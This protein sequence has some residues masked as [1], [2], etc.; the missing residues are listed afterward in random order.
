MW[1]N[2]GHNE[3]LEAKQMVEVKV[4]PCP[5]CGSNE[6]LSITTRETFDKLVAE[7]G[8]ALISI[9][10]HNCDLEFKDFDRENINDYDLVKTRLLRNWNKR[11]EAVYGDQEDT[12]G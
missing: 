5:F 1:W 8:G 9:V 2:E 6:R 4:K 11:K 10:C 12:E 7:N 3:P